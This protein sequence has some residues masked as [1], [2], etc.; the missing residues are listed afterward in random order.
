MAFKLPGK[1]MASGTSAHSS[2]LKMATAAP[3]K[4]S[5]SDA[6]KEADKSKYKTEAEFITAAKAWN[7]EKYGTTEPTREAKKLKPSYSDVTDVKSGKEKLEAMTTYKAK[8]KVRTDTETKAF[9]EK[10]AKETVE[11]HAESPKT[12]KRTKTG[13]LGVQIGNIFR[14]KKKKK[15]PYRKVIKKT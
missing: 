2:A 9:R 11:K 4:L 10:Q 3:T 1:S 12:K 15:N 5:Y 6:Y 14:K 7:R 8:E 13:K